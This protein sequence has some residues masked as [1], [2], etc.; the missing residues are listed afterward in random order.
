MGTRCLPVF[1]YLPLTQ[2][3]VK[4]LPY[5]AIKDFAPISLFIRSPLVLAVSN[6]LGTK[7]LKSFL[8]LANPEATSTLPAPGSEAP[9]NLAAELLKSVGGFQ[10]GGSAFTRAAPAG[11]P[12]DIIRRLNTES[13]KALADREVRERFESQGNEVV[14]GNARSLGQMDRRAV[15]EVGTRD[16][17]T[18]RLPRN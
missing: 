2:Y 14:G 1:D 17:R 5:E 13:N 10:C 18:S 9:A 6:G 3:L 11:T 15:R 8:Q 16:P 4:N 12:G 7:D